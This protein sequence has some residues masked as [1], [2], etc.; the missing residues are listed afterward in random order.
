[1]ASKNSTTRRTSLVFDGAVSPKLT[2]SAARAKAAIDGVKRKADDSSKGL[3]N[4]GARVA[5]VATT[6][7]AG[8]AKLAMFGANAGGLIPVIAAV[9]ST[10]AA[11]AGA[12][13]ILPGAL[14]AAGV[15][16]LTMKAAFAGMGDAIGGD[17]EALAKL[18][19]AAQGFAR[20]A[21]GIVDQFGQVR[22]SIQEAFFT[23]LPERVAALGTTYMP[24]LKTGLTGV[25]TAAG[26]AAKSFLDM[27][28]GA[29]A[30]DQVRTVM[31]ASEKVT[32]NFG[33]ALAPIGDALLRIS[34]TGSVVFADL[35]AGVGGASQRFAEFIARIQESGRLEEIMRGGIE[36]IKQLGGFLSDIVAIG[37]NVFGPLVEGAGA[38]NA[39]LSAVLDV[40]REFTAQQAFRDLIVTI[41]QAMSQLAAVVGGVLSTALNAVLP[42]ASQ[43]V[44]LLADHLAKMLPVVGPL[45][46]QF[47]VFFGQLLLAVTPLIQPLLTIIQTI[48]PIFAGLMSRVMEVITPLLPKFQ[49]LA[50]KIGVA[51]SEAMVTLG[52]KLTD[53]ANKL[54]DMFESL[55]P[56]LSKLM[57]FAMIVVPL[58]IGSS[59]WLADKLLWLIDNA[60]KPLV[61]AWRGVSDAVT[62]AWDIINPVVAGG[63]DRTKSDMGRLSD[64]P[65]KVG[66]WFDGAKNAAQGALNNLVGWVSGIPG[67]IAG[68]L[69]NLGSVLWSAGRSVIDGFVNGITSAFN[70]VRSTL[71]NLT[72][73]LPNWK[74]PAPVDAKILTPAGQLIMDSLIAGFEKGSHDVRKYL[75]GFTSAIPGMALSTA[76]YGS[77]TANSTPTVNVAAPNTEVIV[78]IDGQEFRG[79]VRNEIDTTNRATRR[80]VAQGSGRGV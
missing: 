2:A 22:T 77:I 68:A 63:V 55:G 6:M 48:L 46:E 11:A 4:F 57:D 39:P 66:G 67:R 56:V 41:G 1:M 38:L 53:I 10:M 70:R 54:G 59:A 20:E 8:S 36:A 37:K 74:G 33:A 18:S 7:A 62:A 78:M 21:K 40:V 28:K 61:N 60:I 19:P 15:A 27:A 29:A 79:M 50:E 42:V 16:G 26:D 47:A 73:M 34:A 9:G 72:S 25:A 58:A 32:R 23:G 69:G 13:L 52:P 49:E 30:Q 3:G 65:G 44:G 43:L 12:A 31:S 5:S 64:L 51:V 75:G 76:T 45:L 24:M 17:A 35:T 80:R 14:A 71:S